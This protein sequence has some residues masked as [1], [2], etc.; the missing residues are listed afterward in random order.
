[1]M[2][3]DLQMNSEQLRSKPPTRCRSP[4][5]SIK[6]FVLCHGMLQLAQLLVSGYLKSSISTIERRYGFSSRKSGI[7]ASFNEVSIG[8]ERGD[9]RWVGAW[10][11]GF[12]VAASFLFLTSLPYLF[13]PQQMPKEEATGNAKE[14]R[15]EEEKKPLPDLVQELTLKQ[16]LKSFPRI[17]LRTLRNPVYLLVVLAQVHLAAMIAGLATFMAKFIERQFTQ[18]ASFSNMMIGERHY[19]LSLWNILV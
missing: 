15:A 9:P 12:V 2:A 6:F 14:P 17:A 7:L 16:F 19:S 3:S 18:T 11:L 1:M 13:F 10:W 4:F 8:L 5:N